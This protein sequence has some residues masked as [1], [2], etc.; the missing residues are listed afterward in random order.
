VRFSVCV[1]ADV[2]EIGFYRH[3]ESLGYDSAWVTDSQMTSASWSAPGD[4]PLLSYWRSMPKCALKRALYS[5][6]LS[7]P[8]MATHSSSL[9]RAR[10]EARPSASVPTG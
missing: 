5:A 7:S 2:D 10:P 3:V 6:S 4:G 1:M 9:I 8:P